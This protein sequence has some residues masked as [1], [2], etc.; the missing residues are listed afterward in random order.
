[1]K[2]LRCTSLF[3]RTSCTFNIDQVNELFDC[4]L[5]CGEKDSGHHNTTHGI[6]YEHMQL[7][8]FNYCVAVWIRIHCE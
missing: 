2:S 5:Y 3:C 6:A 7:S 8:V 4:V 1:M